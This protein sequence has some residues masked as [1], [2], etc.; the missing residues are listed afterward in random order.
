MTDRELHSL[1]SLIIIIN[2]Y[3]HNNEIKYASYFII[4]FNI[5]FFRFCLTQKTNFYRINVRHIVNIH[6]HKNVFLFSPFYDFVYLTNIAP[7][8]K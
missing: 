3:C 5:F 1:N 6:E 4:S 2:L 8:K 7:V